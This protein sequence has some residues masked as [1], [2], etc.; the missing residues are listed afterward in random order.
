MEHATP[1][2]SPK[3]PVDPV[4]E[5]SPAAHS[6]RLG[7]G[8]KEDE[9]QVTGTRHVPVQGAPE[10][11][12]KV[13]TPSAKP[14]SPA[15]GKNPAPSSDLPALEA[16]SIPSL[17]EEYFTRL[18]QHKNLETELVSLIQKR[19]QVLIFSCYLLH[20]YTLPSPQAPRLSLVDE[21]GA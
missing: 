12:V 10:T 13:Q 15:K 4:P 9:V 7:S 5:S 14:T 8:T 19:Y 11:L 17:C 18:S 6:P 16:M 1:V 20:N 3:K 21:L 2:S